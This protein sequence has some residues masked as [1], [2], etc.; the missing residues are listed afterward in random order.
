VTLD[1][2]GTAAPGQPGSAPT[3][4]RPDQNAAQ[5]ALERYTA[6][7]RRSRV[8]YF[9]LIATAVVI[10]GVT[11]GVVWSRGEAAHTTLRTAAHPAPAIPL[12]PPSPV[13]A[14]AWHSP[15]HTAIGTPYWGGTVITY[16]TDSVRGR[17]GATGT[18]TWS[19][20][21]TDRRLCQA[22]QSQG[23]T[24][25]VFE[26]HGNCDEVTALDSATG[27]RKWT[28]TLDKD[29]QPL[30]G[31]PGYSLTPYAVMFTAAR[32]IYTIDPA[33]GLD[34]WVYQPPGCTINGAVLGAQGALISQT[35]A[36]PKCAGLTYCGPGPQLL[37]RDASAA[38]SDDD[39]QKANPD[40]IKWDLIGNRAVPASADQLISALDPS[41]GR[42]Q[43]LA[44]AKGKTL[45]RLD[46]HRRAASTGAIT[47]VASDRA[48][49]L[50][51]A[52][53]TYA[54]AVTDAKVL[55][56]RPAATAPTIIQPAQP[57]IPPV[58]GRST[59]AVANPAGIQLLDTSTGKPT[60]TFPVAV[61][62]DSRAHR[63]GS[64]FVLTGSSTT[65]YR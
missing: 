63:F 10:L 28:R 2:P 16:S 62:A 9:S 40:Q 49:L 4:E 61:P 15:D 32:V 35:C 43:V 56:T 8:V 65:V 11:V 3:H 54:V 21:R 52:G 64:G 34:R 50:W 39:K 13:L 23:V 27:A 46:L 38:R 47:A 17:N 55:W 19:Y 44:A 12:R 5:A 58:L 24:V 57:A 29:H 26:L 7:M 30:N 36:R 60:R 22:I 25:A 45:T 59:V 31:H 41:T 48:E 14:Q 18:I 1:Q 53:M 42:L 33:T 6:R 51:I 37:L 20:T